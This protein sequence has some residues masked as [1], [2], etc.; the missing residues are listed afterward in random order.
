M[1]LHISDHQYGQ[2]VVDSIYNG[3]YPDS[4]EVVSG[5]LPQSALSTILAQINQAREDVKV[6]SRRY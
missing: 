6:G 4:E 2:A 3:S 1:S 5:E